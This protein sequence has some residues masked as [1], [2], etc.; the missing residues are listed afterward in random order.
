MA[1]SD[2]IQAYRNAYKTDETIEVYEDECGSCQIYYPD[3]H[4]H[5]GL[6]EE[7]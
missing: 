4:P 7:E 3:D 6:L 5:S 1:L 2:E